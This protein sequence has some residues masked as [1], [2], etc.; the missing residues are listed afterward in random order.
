MS[1]ARPRKTKTYAKKKAPRTVAVY[2]NPP[3]ARRYNQRKAP[4]N[5]FLG[6]EKP[7]SLGANIGAFVGHGAQQLIKAITGFGEYHIEK[8]S[9]LEGGMSPPQV[10][11]TVSKGGFIVRHREYIADV[12]AS[13]TFTNKAY[14]INPG[15]R[16]S[17]P[18]LSQ[19]AKAFELYRLRGLVYEFKSMSSDA[20]LSTSASSALGTV[21]MAT[22]YN[23]LSNPFTNL[24]ALQNHEFSNASKPSC[25]FYH[26][27]ECKKS[28]T[29]VSELY[30]RTGAV[31]SNAD[32]RLYDIG[33]F[34]IATS[35]MQNATGVIGQLWCTYEIEFYQAKY[36]APTG[37]LSDHIFNSSC[38]S[39]Q[40]LGLAH[41]FMDGNSLG[42]SLTP[43]TLTF[44]T[45]IRD[46]VYL[47]LMRYVSAS[48]AYVAP[49]LSD[50]PIAS[51]ELLTVWGNNTIPDVSTNGNSD[52][53]TST[54]FHLSYVVKVNA[55]GLVLTWGT[56]GTIPASSMDL[57]VT[58]WDADIVN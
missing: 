49:T 36:D 41:E 35:G 11:N 44:P 25:D 56:G 2:Q 47:I 3:R 48:G 20:V 8:N 43:T 12:N 55:P 19:I 10:I 33:Q 50:P 52:S 31:E 51:G 13:S 21:A 57:F 34:N 53:V 15:L 18:Y 7:D 40:P 4:S 42:L 39:A 26:P 22:Q 27:V 16:G 17:F 1:T 58:Q 28:L 54:T 30:V 24:I 9:I 23:S 37:I 46:G 32:I 6:I 14:D 38:A 29:A 5:K 45:N